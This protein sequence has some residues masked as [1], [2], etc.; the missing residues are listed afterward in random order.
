MLGLFYSALLHISGFLI[1]LTHRFAKLLRIT[2]QDGDLVTVLIPTHNRVEMLL[3][4]SLK[5]VLAQTHTNLEIIVLAHGCT[6][7]TESRVNELEDA[8]I[9][10]VNVPRKK[11]GYPDRPEFHWLMGPTKP[12]NV[13][14]SRAKGQFVAIIGDDDEWVAN[15]IERA[16]RCLNEFDADFYSSKG[17]VIIDGNF[18]E[19]TQGNKIGA[20]TIGGVS[21]WV[22]RIYLK[23]LKW[24][25]HSWR[26]A[27]NRPNDID[28]G[29]RVRL[30][31]VP[32]HFDDFVGRLWRNRPGESKIGLA[33]YLEFQTQNSPG[34]PE[35]PVENGEGFGKKR[36]V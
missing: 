16:L 5:S 7:D 34:S 9:R 4:R 30:L 31:G 26:K 6:D 2:Q 32:T 13:G 11:L 19:I 25:I 28:F 12:L 20:Y 1:V 15:H 35:L 27:W 24:N 10:L 23:R 22:Y 18:V 3:E 14:H 29:A 17:E 33:A 36:P 21:T 8:R